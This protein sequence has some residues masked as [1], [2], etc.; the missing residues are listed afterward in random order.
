MRAESIRAHLKTCSI[1]QERTTTINHAFASA[2][3]PSSDVSSSAVGEALAALGQNPDADLACVYCGAEAQTWGH[4]TGLVQN[5]ELAGFGR[6]IGNLV[7]RC[8]HCNSRKGSKDW[9]RFDALRA[10]IHL[11]MQEADLFDVVAKHS[12]VGAVGSYAGPEW[13]TYRRH[14]SAD[15]GIDLAD[16]IPTDRFLDDL[17]LD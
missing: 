8:R 15:T 9:Q 3:A 7:P 4:L 11:L 16:L 13:K 6:Q 1:Y 2:L 17:G 10:Q 5:S 12:G 14:V